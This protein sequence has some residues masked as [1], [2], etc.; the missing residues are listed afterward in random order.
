MFAL[1]R[2]LSIWLLFG[3]SLAGYLLVSRWFPL[4]PYHDQLPLQDI[5]SLAPSLN[6]AL[7]YALLL[8]VLF[9]CYGLAYRRIGRAPERQHLLF[10]FVLPLLFS[11][12]LIFTYP[13]NA[14]DLYRYYLGGRITV[15]HGQSPLSVPPGAL[16]QDPLMLLAD[17]WIEGTSPYGPAWEIAAAGIVFAARG[18]LFLALVLLKAFTAAIHLAIGILIWH[19][20]AEQSPATRAARTLLWTWNPALLLIFVANGHN[21]VLMLFWLLLGAWLQQRGRPVAG[22][23]VMTLSPLSKAIGLLPLPFF[24]LSAWRRLPGL[25]E[26]LRAF[27]PAAAGS[28]L[29]AALLFLPFGSPLALL[30]RLQEEAGQ[31]GGFSPLVLLIL[32]GRQ[33]GWTMA[34]RPLSAAATLLFG[35]AVLWL[36]WLTWRGRAPW[37]G[38]ADIFAGYLLQALRFRIW[39][40]S[41]LLPWLLLD[42]DE[43]GPDQ[44][45]FRLRAGLLFLVTGQL[46]PLIYGHVRV[47]LLGRDQV[48]AHLI[49]V[50]FTFLLPLLLAW[51]GG[52]Y[53]VGS[54][55]SR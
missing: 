40:T 45:G 8:V 9:A 28:L 36:L 14:T 23:V 26:R 10:L 18:N 34:V 49:G 43:A 19:L 32:M 53:S 25:R 48:L 29:L 21:D 7:A 37:R 16:L 33:L 39:Y 4:R 47:Y 15:V 42:I 1:N 6:Q 2:Q 52:R 17:E 41:W 38:V 50:P 27:V 51:V 55:D 24:W 20:L 12:P 5:R 31:G 13:Y 22:L 46:S 35:A 54:S 3:A 30:L 11:L 44:L